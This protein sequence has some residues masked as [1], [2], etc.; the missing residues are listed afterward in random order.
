MQQITVS[1]VVDNG[2]ASFNTWVEKDNRLKV[3]KVIVFKD[4]DL[5]DYEWTIQHIYDQEIEFDTIDKQRDF[6]NN[7]Y[8]KHEGLKLN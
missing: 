8:D 7:N 3:G 2:I 4:P 6:D 1:R 5:K